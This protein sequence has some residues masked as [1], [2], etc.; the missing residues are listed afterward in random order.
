MTL[1]SLM[2]IH[3]LLKDNLEAAKE[4]EAECRE[5][6]ESIWRGIDDENAFNSLSFDEQKTWAQDKTMEGCWHDAAEEY[7][8]ALA[9]LEE[10]DWA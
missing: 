3:S 4:H 7:A 9:D 5:S 2:T 1:K 8:A 6:R 10:H